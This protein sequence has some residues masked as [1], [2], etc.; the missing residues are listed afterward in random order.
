MIP[1]LSGIIIGQGES[2]TTRKAFML[3]LVYVLSM[4][5]TYTAA[6]IVVGLS[7]ENV[8]ALFQ[9][10]WILSTFSA[11]F[12]LLSL[13]MFGLY[14]LQIPSAIQSRLATITN[15]QQSGTFIGAGIMGL[16]SALIVGPCVTA[17]LI[18]ALIY[19]AQTGD[20]VLGGAALFSLSLGMGIPLIVIGTSA[21]KFIPKAGDW[22]NNINV[23]FGVTLLAVAIWLL[24]RIV[25][26]T[27]TMLLYAVL[28]IGY[29]AYLGLPQLH[30]ADNSQRALISKGLGLLLLIYGVILM[31]GASI[32]GGSVLQP[33]KGLQGTINSLNNTSQ[34]SLAFERIKGLTGLQQALDKAKQTQQPVMLDLYADWCVACKEMEAYTFSNNAVKTTLSAFMLIQAD[35]TSNDDE[36]KAL[37]KELGVFGPPATVFYDMEGNEIEGTRIVGYMKAKEFNA[38]L[39]LILM[40]AMGQ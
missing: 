34:H 19:I 5:M 31:V 1:I 15:R 3:S 6:G 36:D 12:V 7:G 13:S 28:L 20:A 21:G 40:I 38:R 32:G 26:E 24:S 11:V 33:L 35:V 14:E 25:H 16:L 23:F 27:V 8:Q 9:N 39:E 2:I 30:A 29:A 18:G 4:A 37:L 22:M 17:P 10:P